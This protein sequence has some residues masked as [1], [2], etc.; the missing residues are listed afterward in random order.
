MYTVYLFI[1]MGQFVFIIEILLPKYILVMNCEL[2]HEE[3][4][5]ERNTHTH[6]HEMMVNIQFHDTKRCTGAYEAIHVE[7]TTTTTSSQ[8]E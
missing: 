3:S 6:T 2:E 8:I 7:T 1:N 4:L 5:Q